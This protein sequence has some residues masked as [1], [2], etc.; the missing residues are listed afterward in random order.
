[1]PHMPEL[2]DT[3]CHLDVSEFDADRAAVLQRAR[4]VGVRRLLIPAVT[5][6]SWA[7]LLE[8]C[9]DDPDLYPALGLHPVYIDTHHDQ[10]LDALE[11][12]LV[13]HRP[14]AVGE[15]G[16]DFYLRDLD[17]ARQ[18]ALFD[19]QLALAAAH[20]LP[21][22][23]HVRKAHNEVIA[24]LKRCRVVGGTIHAFNGSLQQAHI[25]LDLGFKLG[26]GGML[27][28]ARSNRL[29]RLA[30]E[31]PIDAIVLETDAP[32]MTVASHHGERNS[33]EYLPDVVGALAELRGQPTEVLA[34]LTSRNACSAF[35]LI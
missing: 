21:V 15:I 31:L 28:Y 13:Q 14:T 18:L 1:M 27:T 29:R 4:Q 35:K 33:P 32:D 34:E 22:A 8:L 9:A 10:D 30:R 23:V 16:L 25:Y 6:S 12:L 7:G 24:A 3:H 5:A 20:R 19:A 11:R 2:F 17:R 26:F